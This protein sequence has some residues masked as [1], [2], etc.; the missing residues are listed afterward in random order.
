MDRQFVGT[1]GLIVIGTRSHTPKNGS[2]ETEAKV[3]SA[4]TMFQQSNV[5]DLV[6]LWEVYGGKAKAAA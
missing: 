2:P 5:A 3:I 4:P 6:A 1:L